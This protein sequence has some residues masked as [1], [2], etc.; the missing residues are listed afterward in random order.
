ML[1]VEL[2]ARR[3]G[4]Q[5][6]RPTNLAGSPAAGPAINLSWTNAN[7]TLETEVWRNGSLLTTRGAGVSSFSDGAVATGVEYTYSLRHKASAS[8]FSSFTSSIIR[9]A[10]P[11]APSLNGPSV[12]TDDVSLSWSAVASATSY[13]VLRGSASGGPYTQIGTPTG[14]TFTDSNRPNGTWYYVVR[15]FN[16]LNESANSNQVSAVVSFSPPIDPPTS[17]SASP[18]HSDRVTLG[19]TN[20]SGTAQIEVYRGTSPDPTDRIA[21]LAAGTTSYADANLTQGTLYYYRIRHINGSSVSSYVADDATTP[22][23]ALTGVS[24]S[25]NTSTD[26]VRLTYSIT[27]PPFAPRVDV[28]DWS[29]TAN[30]VSVPGANDVGASPVLIATYGDIVPIPTGTTV[31]GTLAYV[32][33]RSGNGTLLDSLTNLTVDFDIGAA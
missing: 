7:G 22:T 30:E 14:T 25:A 15:A 29:D 6:P 21:T 28:G 16:G 19:W 13:R 3:A 27:N 5:V 23:S 32:R 20:G 9:S 1:F 10:T 4:A 11:P 33:L 26:Q 31:T 2:L 17:F 12:S 18:S 8:S 24:L